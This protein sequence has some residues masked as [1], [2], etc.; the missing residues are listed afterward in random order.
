MPA[1]PA[2]TGNWADA[3]DA[4]VRRKLDAWSG[5]IP[6]MVSKFF[7]VSDTDRET[8]SILTTGDLG[9][10][11]EFTGNIFFDTVK[12]NYRKNI[13]Q[14]E[15]VK[16][17][18]IQYRLIKTQQVQVVNSILEALSQALPL[19]WITSAF[20]WF[21]NGFSGTSYTSADG[22]SLFN[23]A[24]TSNV[25]G[26]S[27]SNLGS[28]ELSYSAVDATVIAMAKFNS[29]NDNP[30][31]DRKP[32]AIVVPVDLESYAKEIVGSK[33]KP[34]LTVNNTNFYYAKFDVIASRVISDTN[35]WAMVNKE[36]MKKSQF[37]FNVVKKETMRDKEITTLVSRWAQYS[38]YGL[39]AAD[40]TWGYAHAVS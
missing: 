33:G 30:L 32:N 2:N 9:P 8:E 26:S 35:N 18:S 21:N 14:V 27:Q 40:W 5:K 12:Q 25:G 19:R 37:W 22:V 3:I 20:S 31:F 15:Y 24:H 29:P 38:F 23:A 16:G 28:S 34:D 1:T 36:R 17:T 4:S 10:A 39:G 7:T 11:E 6:D 13:T